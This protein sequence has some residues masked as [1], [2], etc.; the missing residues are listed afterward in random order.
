M[1]YSSPVVW[2]SQYYYPAYYY[3]AYYGYYYGAFS[4][5]PHYDYRSFDRHQLTPHFDYH[6]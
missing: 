5:L 2:Y 3:P 6:Q 4:P 1:T